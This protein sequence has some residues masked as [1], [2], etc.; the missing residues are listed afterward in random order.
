M[1]VRHR[2]SYIQVKHA[3]IIPTRPRDGYARRSESLR[4]DRNTL[5]HTTETQNLKNTLPL[6]ESNCV[7]LLSVKTLVLVVRRAEIFIR[8]A[9]WVRPGG[10]TR[11]R[12][13]VCFSRV[14]SSRSNR[15]GKNGR[16][17]AARVEI[18]QKHCTTHA[19]INN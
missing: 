12:G 3:I 4:G 13:L 14:P 9:A 6:A 7:E 2:T 5:T 16:P 11:R 19:R 8:T 15:N 1:L 17:V 10:G 18:R